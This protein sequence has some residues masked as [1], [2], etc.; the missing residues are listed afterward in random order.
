[1]KILIVD[2]DDVALDVLEHALTQA[3]HEVVAAHDGREALELLQ[4]DSCRL[5]IS[6]WMMPEMDGLELCRQIR[7]TGSG[8][9]IYVLLLT[10]RGETKDIVEGFSAGADDFITK[11]FDPDELCVR[12]GAGERILSLDK[13]DLDIFDTA[14]LSA[15]FGVPGHIKRESPDEEPSVDP[16]TQSPVTAVAL[17]DQLST[18]TRNGSASC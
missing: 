2:D 7:S 1:M 6:D 9:Y 15:W 4:T 12:V 10:C 14:R 11:P 13:Y 8:P 18:G 5:V 17:T 3:G 16:R